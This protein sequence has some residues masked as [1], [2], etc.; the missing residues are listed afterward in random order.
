[1]IK[2]YLKSN[3]QEVKIGDTI[4]VSSQTNTPFGVGTTVIHVTMTQDLIPMLIE[5]DV[6]EKREM[7]EKKDLKY[8]VRRV[9]RRFDM[10][11]PEAEDMLGT[12]VGAE[13]VVAFTMLLKEISL[14][15]NKDID[16][17]KLPKVYVVSTVNGKVYEVLKKDIKTYAH[18]A[19]F[20]SK[21][22]A[23]EALE[24]LKHLHQHMYGK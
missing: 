16:I 20:K 12:F 8:Y 21:E 22:Q 17:S 19:A 9:A 6:I 24:L 2:Y 18:F 10:T 5:H 3:G 15:M 11:F 7:N 4:K 13:P 23:Y 1:M 14:Y